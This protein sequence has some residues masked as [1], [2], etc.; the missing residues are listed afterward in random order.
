MEIRYSK[1]SLKFLAK[2]DKPTIKRIT[3]KLSPPTAPSTVFL[4]LI[5]GASLCLPKAHPTKYAP[6]SVSHAAAQISTV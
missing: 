4:G 1:N 3:E 2:T 6:V 5:T